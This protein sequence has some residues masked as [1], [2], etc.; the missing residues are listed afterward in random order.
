MKKKEKVG[1]CV[2]ARCCW[3]P[4]SDDMR[5]MK[6]I[7]FEWNA[8]IGRTQCEIRPLLEEEHTSSL[9]YS[10]PFSFSLFQC[11]CMQTMM[12]T[13][14]VQLHSSRWPKLLRKYCTKWPL[15]WILWRLNWY[16]AI[17]SSRDLFIISMKYRSSRLVFSFVTFPSFLSSHKAM[18][19]LLRIVLHIGA[20]DQIEEN[21]LAAEE[22]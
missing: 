7:R 18:I 1:H 20:I 11:A 22:W 9:L 6:N 14:S 10:F 16:K 8:R 2:Y 4:T 15:V 3:E 13:R 12:Y 5:S 21:L 17:G 19:T